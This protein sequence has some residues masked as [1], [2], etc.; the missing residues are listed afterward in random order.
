M[1]KD[2][3]P[4]LVPTFKLDG[5]AQLYKTPAGYR[6]REV[7]HKHPHTSGEQAP[8]ILLRMKNGR[9]KGGAPPGR[10]L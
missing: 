4:E 8:D 2:G 3:K 1:L 7:A 5:E 10:W 6:P 9:F